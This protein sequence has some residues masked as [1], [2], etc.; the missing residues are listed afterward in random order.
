MDL[1]QRPRP[2][3]MPAYYL[4]YLAAVP[5]PELFAALEH[6][7]TRFADLLERVGEE[8]AGHRYAPGKWS[9]R[10]VLQ[11]VIDTERIMA[12]RALRFARHDETPLPGFDENAYAAV[13][14]ADRRTLADL[15]GEAE[16]LR[17]STIDLFTSFT[18]QMLRRQGIASGHTVS[19]R[20]IG[21]IIAGHAAHHRSIIHQ[22]YL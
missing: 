22:R 8:R 12:Y 18:P 5:V 16:R 10:E 4:G 21:W 3:E 1:L 13:C 15:V 2:E 19:V 14:D 9:I 6:G 7:D 17:R 20:A 11:H